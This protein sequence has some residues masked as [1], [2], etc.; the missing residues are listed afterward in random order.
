MKYPMETLDNDEDDGTMVQSL[1]DLRTAVIGRKIVKV[2]I[3][4][5]AER[6]RYA[7][8]GDE[9]A[10]VISLDN[11][12]QVELVGTRDCCASTEVEAFLLHPEMIDH[13]ILG[14]GTTDGF[15]TW[16]IFADYGDILDLTV[17]WSSGNPFY[18][19]Y[20]FKIQVKDL[21]EGE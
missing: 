18:Y 10:T 21:K 7:D 8:Y 19:S 2:E 6:V 11:G 16:H 5:A 4:P 20:G 3:I 13:A 12:T 14:V 1:E 17:S 9:E 15:T